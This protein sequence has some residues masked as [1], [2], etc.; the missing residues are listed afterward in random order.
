MNRG[1]VWRGVDI[2]VDV[3]LE[4][5]KGRPLDEVVVENP[6]DEDAARAKIIAT[7]MDA[8]TWLIVAM[9]IVLSASGCGSALK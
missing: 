3:W 5:D 1:D 4:E 7:S 8:G 6:S 2:D 9:L